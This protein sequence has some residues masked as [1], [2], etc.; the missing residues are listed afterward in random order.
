MSVRNANIVSD[1]KASDMI[2]RALTKTFIHSPLV[3]FEPL[4]KITNGKNKEN[5]RLN[6]GCVNYTN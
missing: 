6:R 1:G 5:T 4:S 3:L 2:G